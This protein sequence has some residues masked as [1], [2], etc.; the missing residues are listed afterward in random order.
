MYVLNSKIENAR[1]AEKKTTTRCGI[2]EIATTRNFVLW[3]FLNKRNASWHVKIWHDAK[4]V[5]WLLKEMTT[6]SSEVEVVE[7]TLKIV[8]V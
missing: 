6:A 1:L 5:S 4:F 3:S 2:R 8:R 7:V